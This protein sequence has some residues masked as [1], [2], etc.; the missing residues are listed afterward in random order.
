VTGRLAAL[1]LLAAAPAWAEPP[2]C[3]FEGQTPKLVVELFFGQSM[4][5]QGLVSRRAWQRFVADTI[6]PA[7]PD[8]FTV[9]DA[10]G[11]YPDPATRV[12]GREPTEV[13]VVAADDSAEFRVRVAGIAD[14]YRRRFAQRSVGILTNT[15]CGVF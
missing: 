8:G 6:T 13:V 1:L 15:G 7:L 14:A 11:Q 5:G 4:K 2:A 12:I 9:Y 10:Y 3:P